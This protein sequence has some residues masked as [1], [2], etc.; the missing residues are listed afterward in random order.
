MFR[1]LLDTFETI[2]L[3]L[4]PWVLWSLCGLLL[5]ILLPLW[6]ESMRA[7]HIRGLIRQINRRPAEEHPDLL[8]KIAELAGKRGGRWVEVANAAIK[9]GQHE[10]RDRAIDK[11]E[12][13]GDFHRDLHRIRKKIGQQKRVHLPHPIAT[14]HTIER[15]CDEGLLTAAK[16]RLEAAKIRFPGLPEWEEYEEKIQALLH[17]G[18]NQEPE[19]E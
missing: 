2:Q 16:E 3:M 13:L 5:V 14:I 4:P 11:I 6:W 15:L 1:R 10:L 12:S 18:E 19:L 8:Q 9:M 7:K 17:T